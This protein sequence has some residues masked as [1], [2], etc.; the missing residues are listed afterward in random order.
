MAAGSPQTPRLAWR[1]VAS[2]AVR[3]AAHSLSVTVAE[4]SASPCAS[5]SACTE[6][7]GGNQEHEGG[8][9]AI[10]IGRVVFPAQL[11]SRSFRIAVSAG[12]RFA[13]GLLRGDRLDAG[14]TNLAAVLQAKAACIDDGGDPALALRFEGA[15]CGVSRTNRCGQEQ[16]CAERDLRPARVLK[17][18]GHRRRAH[19]ALFMP[20]IHSA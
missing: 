2:A 13:A 11:T 4:T 14:E 15:A 18:G 1:A 20:T 10:A 3:T 16:D 12:A 7:L 17:F 5:S 19:G 9:A 8:L 6:V